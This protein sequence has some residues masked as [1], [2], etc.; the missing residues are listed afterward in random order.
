MKNFKSMA[1][2]LEKDRHPTPSRGLVDRRGDKGDQREA[3][4]PNNDRA[5]RAA[6]ANGRGKR[7][8]LARR[9]SDA[10]QKRPLEACGDIRHSGQA[11]EKALV[12]NRRPI[13]GNQGL[14]NPKT[15][16]AKGQ[17]EQRGHAN[18][19]RRE[20]KALGEGYGGIMAGRKT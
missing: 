5:P 7:M 4:A 1:I 8:E 11:R 15:G 17:H 6:V 20:E 18:Q 2:A 12:P 10:A 19:R 13:S 14:A 9:L 16:K 3:Q